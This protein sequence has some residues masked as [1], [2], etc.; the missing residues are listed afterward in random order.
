M[1][2]ISY[3]IAVLALCATFLVLVTQLVRVTGHKNN[4]PSLR[5]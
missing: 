4:R 2:T 5:N 3:L 1:L